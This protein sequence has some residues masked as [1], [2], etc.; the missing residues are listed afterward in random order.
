[1]KKRKREDRLAIVKACVDIE[2]SDD[3]LEHQQ[4]GFSKSHKT[5]DQIFTPIN[6]RLKGVT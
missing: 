4:S 6:E 3:E 2:Q 1:M 5:N